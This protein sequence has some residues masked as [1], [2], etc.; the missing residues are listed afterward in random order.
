MAAQ[1]ESSQSRLIAV[2]DFA[3]QE[4]MPGVQGPQPVD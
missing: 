3:W 2:N 4:L 1:H